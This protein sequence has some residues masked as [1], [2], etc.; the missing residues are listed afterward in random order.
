[1]VQPNTAKGGGGFVYVQPD[2]IK[3]QINW[4]KIHSCTLLKRDLLVLL[5]SNPVSQYYMTKYGDMLIAIATFLRALT[6]HIW[7]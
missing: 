5:S 1:M 7:E 4:A 6:F 2:T 3:I